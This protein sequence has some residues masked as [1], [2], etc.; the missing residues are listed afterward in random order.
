MSTAKEELPG[1]EFEGPM[2]HFW[3]M[4]EVPMPAL[5]AAIAECLDELIKRGFSESQI[6]EMVHS[7]QVDR[8]E[9]MIHRLQQGER[10]V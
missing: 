4:E 8:I 9:E 3:V 7:L 1:M 2:G 6:M 5:I 10:N